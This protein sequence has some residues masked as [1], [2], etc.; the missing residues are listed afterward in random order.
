MNEAYKEFLKNMIMSRMI[1][2]IGFVKHFS[3]SF[4]FKVIRG[5]KLIYGDYKN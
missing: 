1:L 4:I 3:I 2:R 5:E